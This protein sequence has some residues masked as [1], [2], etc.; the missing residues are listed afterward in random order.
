MVNFLVK[1]WQ[2]L[3]T[4]KETNKTMKNPKAFYDVFRRYHGALT[5]AEVDS[6]E[7]LLAAAAKEGLSTKHT[8]VVL[9]QC[10]H[11][12]GRRFTPIKE[13][14][15]RYHK[16]QNPS[17][18][19]VAAR[20]E[21]AFAKGQLPWVKT[22]YWRADASGCYWFGRGLIQITHKA[23]YQ[24]LGEV[25]G[26]DL[27]T[28]PSVALDPVIAARIAVVGCARG[29]FTGYRLSDAKTDE[30]Y[31]RVVNGDYRDKALQADLSDYYKRFEAALSAGGW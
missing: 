13:T 30:D 2:A 31:R 19:T 21:T 25:L 22:P 26:L 17:D 9:G 18:A 24:K 1:L 23:N 29:L 11:E 10:Y 16:D 6:L 7:A 14:V 15:F 12:A 8:A 28:D 3:F 20:L 5:Q 27:T 4:K